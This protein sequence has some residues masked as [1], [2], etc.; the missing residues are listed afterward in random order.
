MVWYGLA[1]RWHLKVFGVAGMLLSSL[2]WLMQTSIKRHM[3]HCVSLS[4]R[5]PPL[6]F[7]T[8]HSCLL[9]VS[10]MEDKETLSYGWNMVWCIPCI[11]AIKKQL[12]SPRM[13][14]S[15]RQ[16]VKWKEG[17]LTMFCEKGKAKAIK[18]T[19]RIIRWECSSAAQHHYFYQAQI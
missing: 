14:W 18:V 19:S 1:Q 17:H 5:C 7:L 6:H 3:S 16:I 2:L 15:E 12:L 13:W 9:L 4:P 10:G 11:T 8:S